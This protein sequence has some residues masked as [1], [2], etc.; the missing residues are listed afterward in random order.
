MIN[1]ELFRKAF[2]IDES[3]P[4]KRG[5]SCDFYT[6]VNG[7]TVAIYRYRHHWLFK[8]GNPKKMR[9]KE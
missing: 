9:K 2:K 7:G 5:R 3:I 1:L 6:T 8:N 4:F